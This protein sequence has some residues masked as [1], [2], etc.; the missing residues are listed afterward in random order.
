MSFIGI[1]IGTGILWLLNAV[2]V[3][4][5]AR[6]LTNRKTAKETVASSSTSQAEV[7]EI[8][9]NTGIYIL[10]DVTVMTIAGFLLGV[11]GGWFFIGFAWK[12]KDWPGMLA[13]IGASLLG[14][15]IHG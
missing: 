15:I 5:I 7:Q 6:V 2:L 10:V 1:L 8:P 4:P 9:I 13:F 11:I 3:T 14:S 12:G